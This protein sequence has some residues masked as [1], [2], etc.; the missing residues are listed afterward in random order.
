M[1]LLDHFLANYGYFAIFGLLMLGIV[2]PFIPDDT[3]LVLS[4]IAVHRGQLQLSTTIGVAY[5]GSLCGITLSYVLG[6]TG[7]IYALERYKPVERWV[8]C[9]MPEVEK[10]FERYGKW[11]LFFGYFIAGVRHFTALAAGTSKVKLRT[12]VLYAWPGGFVW[13]VSFISIG[14]F[15]GAEWEQVRQRF[16]RGALIAAALVAAIAIVGWY[17]RKRGDIRV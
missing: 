17:I 16:N 6:R 5:A 4:G 13:V 8:N 2:G 7:V 10:W 12:F 14:Y 15:L 1:E 3:I 11:T 9:H